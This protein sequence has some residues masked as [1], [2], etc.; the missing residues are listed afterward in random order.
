M[1]EPRRLSAE[2]K[3]KRVVSVCRIS[4]GHA[5]LQVHSVY[6]FNAQHRRE[7]IG[8]GRVVVLNI[9]SRI[10]SISVTAVIVV[11]VSP[12]RGKRFARIQRSA[13]IYEIL[14]SVPVRSERPIAVVRKTGNGKSVYVA[15]TLRSP[16][17]AC[18]YL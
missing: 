1:L 9:K 5:A 13:V 12:R 14:I 10:E 2:E 11:F 3:G 16:A 4:D 15:C 8:I 17:Y 7:I 6:K 18:K